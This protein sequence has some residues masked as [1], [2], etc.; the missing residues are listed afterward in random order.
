MEFFHK[1]TQVPPERGDLL[2]SEPFLPDP[3]FER[4]VV[5]LCE[6]DDNGSFGFVLNQK[7]QVNLDEVIEEVNEAKAPVFV[8][9]PV[10]RN[11]LHYLHRSEQ[12]GD[13]SKEIMNGIM[14][15]VNFENLLYSVNT[16]I[17]D[18]SDIKFFVGYS[19]WSPGQLEEELKANSWIVYKS[20]GKELVFDT[21]SKELWKIAM[22]D[23]GG[24]YKMMSNY[25]SDPR[26]N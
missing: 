16:K 18:L 10:E 6:H 4:S 1:H 14:W 11:T 13:D 9:G 26:L 25:P 22:N 23:L 7:S 20:A 17:I 2:I 5:Y 19:G 21:D 3:N 15:G 12:L 8:G 24:K